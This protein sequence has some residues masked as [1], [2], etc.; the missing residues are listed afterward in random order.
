MTDNVETN[1]QEAEVAT[2]SLSPEDQKSLL[3]ARKELRFSQMTFQL[4]EKDFKLFCMNLFRKYKL[5]DTDSITDQ[6]N[7]VRGK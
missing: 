7:I 3:E 2:E 1:N 6:G 4:A 5:S